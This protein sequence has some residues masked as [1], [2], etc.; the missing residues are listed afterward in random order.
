MYWIAL[1]PSPD[2][3]TAWS[4]WALRFTP[5]V[6]QA[7]GALLLEISGSERL[8]GGRQRLIRG[9]VEGNQLLARAPWAQGATSLIALALL[10]A[11]RLGLARPA[12]VPQ[13]L[14]LHL[15]AAALDHAPTLERAGC[16]TWGELRA[17]PR[18]GVARRFGAGLLEAL[19]AAHGERPERHAWLRLPEVFNLNLELQALATTAPELMDGALHLLRQLQIWLQARNLG[20]L[21]L[22][23]EWTLDLRRL[24]GVKLPRC[25]QL[26]VRTAQPTQ[27]MAH[28]RKLVA[29]HLARAVLSAPA[30]HLR[31][32]SLETVPWGGLPTSLL[33]ED[34][35]QGE[36][37][38]QLVERLSVRLGEDKV[39]VPQLHPDH[40]PERMQSWV[41]ARTASKGSAPAACADALFPPWLLPQPL[42]LDVRRDTPHY[43]GPLRLLSRPQRIEAAWWDAQ[44]QG[45]ALRD[46]FIARSE[47]AGLLW[48]YRERPDSVAEGP[49][50]AR[51]F[52][53][54]LYA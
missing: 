30:N 36:K 47:Q 14:P 43:G 48:I 42:Q 15:L 1:W 54:G 19:D 38:H 12:R 16:R 18:S 4:W 20:V 8:F 41:P 5:R 21:G 31:L 51:W 33:A 28:L 34:N 13:D 2:E 50:R 52:L 46:Y 7:E 49:A 37:L 23:L 39:V 44:G 40:R 3:F 6:A 17:L 29:E 9:F 22:E 53:H 32:R 11:D 10:K 25:E 45:L 24:N 35:V 27:D 26:A